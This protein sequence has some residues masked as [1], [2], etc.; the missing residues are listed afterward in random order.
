MAVTEL[1]ELVSFANFVW[2]C[3]RWNVTK[4]AAPSSGICTAR[5]RYEGPSQRGRLQLLRS[6]ETSLTALANVTVHNSGT[7][8]AQQHSST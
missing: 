1:F 4:K 2:K 5:K 8:A 6:T 7:T 3:P